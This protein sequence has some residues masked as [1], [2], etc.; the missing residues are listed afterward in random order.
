MKNDEKQI[1]WL[2]QGDPSIRYQTS[3]DLLNADARVIARERENILN[4]GWGKQLMELQQANGTWCDALYSPKWTSTFYTVLLLKRMGAGHHPRIDKACRILL[5]KGF[6]KD[7]G[8]NYWKTWKQGESCVTGMLLSMLC[9][10]GI[11]DDRPLSMIDYLISQQMPDQGWNCDRY[12]G[13]RHSSFH[14]TISVLEGLWEAERFFSDPGL[15]HSLQEKQT[16]GIEFLL[17]HHLYKSNTTWKP[18]DPKMTKLAFPP[19]WHFD[20][21]RGLDYFQEKEIPKDPRMIDAI[22][23]LLKKQT[24]EGVWKLEQKY[25]GKIFFDLEKT[26][27]KSRWNTLRALRILQWW[28]NQPD[29]INT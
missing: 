25:P 16:Q 6:Y 4:E 20:I 22:E 19:R 13:A 24:P 27:Q 12:R 15:V 7:G 10:F 28:G 2:L 9:H 17:D 14:T 1:T 26:G 21:M 5:D 8:I 23:L 18:V 3:R 29:T 11:K